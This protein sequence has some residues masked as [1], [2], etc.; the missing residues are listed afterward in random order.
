[1]SEAIFKEGDRVRVHSRYAPE[2]VQPFRGLIQEG[3]PAK[4]M[5][6]AREGRVATIVFDVRRKGARQ[7]YLSGVS[8]AWL[9]TADE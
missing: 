1:M 5:S 9:E 3:R 4:V 8:V 2:Y 7:R 6:M